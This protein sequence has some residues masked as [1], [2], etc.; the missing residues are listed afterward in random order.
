MDLNTI[1]IPLFSILLTFDTLFSKTN[2][3]IPYLKVNK[4]LWSPLFLDDVAGS[5]MTWILYEIANMYHY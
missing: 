4:N 5:L 1:L 3:L 2:F